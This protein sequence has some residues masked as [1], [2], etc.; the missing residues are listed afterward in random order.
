[1]RVTVSRCRLSQKKKE[2]KGEEICKNGVLHGEERKKG[3]WRHIDRS[4]TKNASPKKFFGEECSGWSERER[5]SRLCQ[6]RPSLGSGV[7]GL[8]CLRTVGIAYALR[9][10]RKPGERR[11]TLFAGNT[12][13]IRCRAKGRILVSSHAAA[14][15]D[16][17]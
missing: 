14:L 9:R 15:T 1:M 12:K 10:R 16:S 2:R 7:S 5:T 11:Q 3:V 13:K 4:G 6:L 17:M 8:D